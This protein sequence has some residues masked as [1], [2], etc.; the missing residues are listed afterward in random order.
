MKRV[1]LVRH[2]ES[3]GNV[4]GTDSGPSTPLTLEG[5]RQALELARR[6]SNVDI[7]T[8]IASPYVRTKETARII[9]ETLNKPI[10]YSD[11]FVEKRTPS[12]MWGKQEG[13][14]RNISESRHFID[15][16]WK[17]SDDDSFEEIR[18]RAIAALAYLLERQ[19]ENLLVVSHGWFLRVLIAIQLFGESLTIDAYRRIWGYLAT[20]NTGLTLVEY[21]PNNINAP[22]NRG[23]RLIT[24]NDHAH[25]G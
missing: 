11:L 3:T 9:N 16:A 24:W 7:D 5:E 2:G 19:E 4:N 18:A 8:I 22:I 1:Y 6:L 17:H 14:F 10:E 20:R 13:D 23:W 12:E 25:L 21:D 15:P